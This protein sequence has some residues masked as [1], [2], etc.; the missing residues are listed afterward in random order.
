MLD[1]H[2][3]RKA[4]ISIVVALVVM[5]IGV[6]AFWPPPLGETAMNV[7][8]SCSFVAGLANL[9]WLYHREDRARERSAARSSGGD[10]KRSTSRAS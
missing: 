7:I 6:A 2:S 10:A 4:Y 1:G 8:G 3:F 5:A 9:F